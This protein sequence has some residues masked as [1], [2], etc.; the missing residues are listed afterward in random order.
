MWQVS[1]FDHTKRQRAQGKETKAVQHANGERHP[2]PVGNSSA[3]FRLERLV[4]KKWRQR[5]RRRRGRSG[6][7][8]AGESHQGHRLR[9]RALPNVVATLCIQGTVTREV[10]AYSIH[11]RRIGCAPPL[12]GLVSSCH[13][14]PCREPTRQYYPAVYWAGSRQKIRSAGV[15]GTFKCASPLRTMKRLGASGDETD[16]KPTVPR[17]VGMEREGAKMAEPSLGLS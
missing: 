14:D 7:I 6:A 10:L 5:R 8:P 9:H 3:T 1:T 12:V 13:S 11:I 16:V 4:S 17:A 2:F 15:R